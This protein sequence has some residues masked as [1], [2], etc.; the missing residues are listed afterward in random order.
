MG[1]AG[2]SDCYSSFHLVAGAKKDPS[3][4]VD[5]SDRFNPA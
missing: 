2:S 3:I 5:I 4:S 1:R